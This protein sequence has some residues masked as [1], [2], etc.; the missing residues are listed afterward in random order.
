[1]RGRFVE[2][3][4]SNDLSNRVFGAQKLNFDIDGIELLKKAEKI[5]SDVN[6]AADRVLDDKDLRKI[7]I[8]QLKEGVRKVDRHGFR[9]DDI[10]DTVA[11]EA[12]NDALKKE[13]YYKLLEIQRLKRLKEMREN[14]ELD[15]SGDDEE[16]EQ[17]MYDE[18]GEMEMEEGEQDI[19]DDG[20]ENYIEM[21]EDGD[22]DEFVSDSDGEEMPEPISAK[23]KG[24]NN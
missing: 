6:V 2:I 21:K 1:M 15:Y 18:E 9:E 12:Q 23:V 8:L 16:G 22:E 3:D 11:N 20:N 13:Y 5:D 19:E 17:D 24:I 14:G 10:G 7:K 4:E